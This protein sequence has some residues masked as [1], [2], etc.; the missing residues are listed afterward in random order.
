MR[1]TD[2]A[3]P[4]GVFVVVIAVTLAGTAVLSFAM[5][6]G[7]GGQADG[8]NIQG[9]SPDQFQPENVNV[10]RD[11]EDGEITVDGSGEDKRILIDSQHSN[12]YDRSDL[13]PVIEA[14]VEAGHKVDFTASGQSTDSFGGGSY[15][16]T[17]QQYD[18]VLIVNPTESFSENERAGLQAYADGDG[19]VAVL[20]EPT[21]LAGGGTFAAPS[22][23]QFGANDLTEDFG[24]RVGA[25]MLYNMDDDANDNNFKSIYAEPSGDG[26]LTDGVD[27]ITLETS[28]YLV[29]NGDN[30]V[31]VVFEAADGTKTLETR[32]TGDYATVVRNDN[33]VFVSDSTFIM[34]DEVYDA[35]NEVFVS[36]LLDFLTSGDK[37][38][39]VPETGGTGTDDGF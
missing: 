29:T 22:P 36:N 9:Q 17:L 25:D 31:D 21:R 10:D 15:N 2:I 1:V 37:A 14:L 7:S 4:I 12:V 8:A 13:E 3:K 33:M 5:G 6:S 11:P 39:D 16:A 23:R 34:E 28:G 19:R 24:A 26:A 30:D 35:D 38:D 20:G 32:R 27:T 18:A